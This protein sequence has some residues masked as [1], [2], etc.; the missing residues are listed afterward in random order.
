MLD[1]GRHFIEVRRG[2]SEDWTRYPVDYTIGSKRQQA[3]ATRLADKRLLVFPIQD[4]RRD[5]RRVDQL[6]ADWW[7][8]RVPPAPTSRVP[9]GPPE[10]IYQTT[11]APC[12]TSQL[13]FANGALPPVSGDI[14]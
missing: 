8:R 5:H 3:Y 2:E 11:C 14:P 4:S 7:T 1:D 12:H 6:L 9:R 10:A 13:G